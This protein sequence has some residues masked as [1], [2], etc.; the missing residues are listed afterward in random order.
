ML[1]FSRLDCGEFPDQVLFTPDELSA[2]EGS[3]PINEKSVH[4]SLRK[5]LQNNS[6]FG[7]K[8]LHQSLHAP[9]M[10]LCARY[11]FVEKRRK[12]ALNPV[13]K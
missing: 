6:W 8:A 12:Y 2:L 3:L 11:L 9:L 1:Y 5:V 7:N 10:K 13:G 4:E